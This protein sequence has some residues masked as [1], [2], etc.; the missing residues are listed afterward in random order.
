MQKIKL[1]FSITII[2]TVIISATLG[3]L[4]AYVRGLRNMNHS[5]AMTY[6]CVLLV[7]SGTLVGNIDSSG[8]NGLI[9]AIERNGDDWAV[10][11]RGWQPHCRAEDRKTYSMALEK[12][13]TAKKKLEELR[14]S[15][16][17][18]KDPNR[19]E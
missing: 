1:V 13:E 16:E 19:V 2:L 17:T 14:S 5:Y 9:D 4:A 8:V 11:V 18:Y 12:W 10:T 7:Q 15:Y 3:Y 6:C